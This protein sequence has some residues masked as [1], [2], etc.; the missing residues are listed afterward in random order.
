M[1]S[2]LRMLFRTLLIRIAENRLTKPSDIREVVNRN[3][4]KSL[5][6]K[7]KENNYKEINLYKLEIFN[8]TKNNKDK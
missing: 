7:S 5:F 4:R 8:S 2:G 6:N 1:L 3:F